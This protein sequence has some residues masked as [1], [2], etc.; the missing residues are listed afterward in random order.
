MNSYLKVMLLQP[1]EIRIL[2]VCT[3]KYFDRMVIYKG[4]AIQSSI[5][6]VMSGCSSSRYTQQSFFSDSPEVLVTFTSDGA[7]AND[8]IKF[9]IIFGNII[10]SPAHDYFDQVV[11]KDTNIVYVCFFIPNEYA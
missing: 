3:E 8:G 7:T 11:D 2:D 4:N 1:I 5:N 9:E 10:V 6:G